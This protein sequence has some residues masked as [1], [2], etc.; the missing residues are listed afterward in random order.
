MGLRMLSRAAVKPG[1]VAL[2]GAVALAWLAGCATSEEIFTRGRIENRCN[3]SIPVCD[4][5]AAC[6]LSQDQYL[7]GDF[8][9]GQKIIVRT[10]DDRAQL[11]TRFLLV[12][13]RYPGTTIFVRAYSTGCGDYSEG[14]AEDV[15]LFELAGGDGIIEY[16]L[17]V[18]GLGDHFVEIFS[19]MSAEFLFRVD[20]ED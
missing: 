19:D 10:E 7:R 16:G 14:L 17:N 15:D 9:G 8:P 5:L 13:E 3:G 1:L 20:I 11:I 18:T 2:A 6:V 4:E 12:D